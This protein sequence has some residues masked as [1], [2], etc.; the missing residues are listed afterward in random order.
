M[1]QDDQP[2][3]PRVLVKYCDE[4]LEFDV[5]VDGT[6][7]SEIKSRLRDP[8]GML[9]SQFELW[10]VGITQ[11]SS[12][13]KKKK[14]ITA[15][16]NLELVKKGETACRDGAA[17]KWEGACQY[18]H[19]SN[20]ECKKSRVCGHY[21]MGKCYYGPDCKFMHP[22][23]TKVP[24]PAKKA[25]ENCRHYL[26]KLKDPT[27]RGC[28]YGDSCRF[29]H[30]DDESDGLT[31]A[32]SSS[33]SSESPPRSPHPRELHSQLQKR[34]KFVS[35]NLNEDV[36]QWLSVLKRRIENELSTLSDLIETTDVGSHH[37]S[38]ISDMEA[39]S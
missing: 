27:R 5:P 18:H 7:I 31:T 14:R 33:S 2:E 29:K 10:H 24:T 23:S 16:T 34:W 28:T 15:T 30:G 39:V 19:S 12:R 26:E 22:D 1:S 13:K 6:T 8:T 37:E 36:H 4:L 11:T 25:D 17:C 9:P 35:Q 21:K 20:D 32:S 38:D 3:P